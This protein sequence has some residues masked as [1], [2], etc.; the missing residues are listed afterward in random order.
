MQNL[1]KYYDHVVKCPCGNRYGVDED[2]TSHEG[3]LCPICVSS[4]IA[5]KVRKAA[6]DKRARGIRFGRSG[7]AKGK[8]L[9]TRLGRRLK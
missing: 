7:P 8:F 5:K 1:E 2:E 4:K 9:K 3:G 6:A